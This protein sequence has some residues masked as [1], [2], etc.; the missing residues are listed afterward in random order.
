MVAELKTGIKYDHAFIASKKDPL[1]VLNNF[2]QAGIFT[3]YVMYEGKDEVRIAG[4]ELA[5]VLVT[6]ERVLLAGMGKTIS[7][8]VS[9]P[10]K[11][12][13]KLLDSLQLKDW[14]AYGYVGFDLVRFYSAYSKAISQPLCQFLIPETELHFNREGVKIKTTKSIELV[15]QI[16]SD[17]TQLPNYEPTSLKVDRSQQS[18]YQQS[19]STLIEAIKEEHLHKAI[20]SR[21]FKLDGALDILGTYKLAAQANNSAR[22][23]CLDLGD[24]RAVGFSPETLIEVNETGFVTTNP[25]AGTRHRGVNAEEDL[26][27][28]NELFTDAKEVKEH[29]LSIWLAQSEIASVCLPETVHIYNFMEVKKYRCV[30]HL[31]S[32][33]GGQLKPD[34][35]FWDALIVLFPGIGENIGFVRPGATSY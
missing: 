28:H 13:E 31:S 2:L 4:G 6:P 11:Q 8:P 9:N 33:V 22:S 1:I 21:S 7:E 24:V 26:Q 16:L 34:H 35:S 30:Q 3:K 29:S 10:L 17:D 23:Y 14:T 25:L 18:D 27:L 32:R 5:T 12:L 20:I 15:K 19:V